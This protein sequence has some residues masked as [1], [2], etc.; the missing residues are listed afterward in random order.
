MKNNNTKKK[1]GVQEGDFSAFFSLKLEKKAFNTEYPVQSRW[2]VY[3]KMN[4]NIERERGKLLFCPSDNHN[5]QTINLGY[6]FYPC[7]SKINP[8]LFVII[9]SLS[10]SSYV[11]DLKVTLSIDDAE[12]VLTPSECPSDTGLLCLNVAIPAGVDQYMFFFS[13]DN[14]AT[15]TWRI[16]SVE[17]TATATGLSD[18]QTGC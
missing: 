6:I 2:V 11:P 13:F 17:T 18:G 9:L 10:F 7:S 4:L 3:S 1:H 15:A 12:T 14:A 16:V 8:I 5:T